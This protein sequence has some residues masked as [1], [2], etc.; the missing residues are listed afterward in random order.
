MSYKKS[1]PSN[2]TAL[3][4]FPTYGKNQTFSEQGCAIN[5]KVRIMN[6]HDPNSKTILYTKIESR[7][8]ILYVYD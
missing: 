4:K 5:I 1:A 6:N 3:F 7:K 2:K 8:S